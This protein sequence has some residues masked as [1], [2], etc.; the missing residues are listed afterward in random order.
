MHVTF[1]IGVSRSRPHDLMTNDHTQITTHR[2]TSESVKAVITRICGGCCYEAAITLI[3]RLSLRESAKAVITRIRGGCRYANPWKLS[4]R[5]SV[6]A[7][8]TRICG[9]CHYANLEAVVTRIR[10]GCR[11]AN[12]WRLS[13]CESVEAVI[14]WVCRGCRCANLWRLLLRESVRQ[15]L[16]H[17]IGSF[18]LWMSLNEC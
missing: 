5:E 2:L 15:G 8:V 3:W 6:E 9:G 12:P 1:P 13:L 7:L 16:F 18:F 17:S 10:G 14:T 4:L 11:Y